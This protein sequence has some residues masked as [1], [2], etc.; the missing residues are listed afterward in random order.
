MHAWRPPCA[1][2]CSGDLPALVLAF[3]FAFQSMRRCTMKVRLFSPPKKIS[4]P[5]LDTLRTS[6]PRSSMERGPSIAI[7]LAHISVGLQQQLCTPS[8]AAQ[9]RPV[10]PNPS[11]PLTSTPLPINC[12]TMRHHSSS[13]LAICFSSSRAPQHFIIER[14]SRVVGFLNQP[15]PHEIIA[16]NICEHMHPCPCTCTIT[17]SISSSRVQLTPTSHQIACPKPTLKALQPHPSAISLFC[18]LFHHQ[19]W[20]NASS[21]HQ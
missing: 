7:S 21:T 2:K 13:P 1:A 16:C 5:H 14:Q 18:T 11:T 6:V 12:F 20:Q 10:L 17:I 4:Q 8:F 19:K 3:M 15:N 9:S